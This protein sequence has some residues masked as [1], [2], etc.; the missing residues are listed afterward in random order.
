VTPRADAKTKRLEI[1]V[2]G[3][4]FSGWDITQLAKR[5]TESVAAHGG[6]DR[7]SLGRRE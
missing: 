5:V 3:V 1:P 4:A 6:I 7:D 2:I